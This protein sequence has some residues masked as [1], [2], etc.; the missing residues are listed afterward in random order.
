[1]QGNEALTTDT[2]LHRGRPIHTV[3]ESHE[4]VGDSVP[5]RLPAGVALE[6]QHYFF[7]QSSRR[8]QKSSR[9]TTR[10]GH[11]S[12]GRMR[13]GPHQ[14]PREALGPQGVALGVGMDT[15]RTYQAP[16]LFVM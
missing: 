2:N 12:L 4:S 8:H 9:R 11:S 10:V 14:L 1:M 16:R 5:R 6:S 7:M 13:E 15:V 3:T